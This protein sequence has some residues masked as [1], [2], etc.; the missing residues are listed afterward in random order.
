LSD[1]DKKKATVEWDQFKKKLS[2]DIA[3]VGEY[4]TFGEPLTTE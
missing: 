1:A 3:I 2:K 4:A